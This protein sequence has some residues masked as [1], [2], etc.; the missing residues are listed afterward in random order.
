MKKVSII[1]ITFLFALLGCNKGKQLANELITVDVTNSY[2]QKE[3]I[4]QDF[5]DVEYIPLDDAEEYTTMGWVHSVGKELVIVRNRL[6]KT[7]GK[8]FMFDRNGKGVR[9]INRLGQSGEEYV[10]LLSILLDENKNEIFV[11]DHFTKRILVYDLFGNFK[12]SFN[13]LV[14]DWYD[15]EI[16]NFDNEHL[17]CHTVADQ[18]IVVSKQDGSIADSVEIPAKENISLSVKVGE[19]DEHVRNRRLIPHYDN[20]WILM[21]PSSDTVY[22]FSSDFSMTPIVV[23][24][25][26]ILSMDTKKSLFPVVFTKSYFFMQIVESKWDMETKAFPTTN[27]IYDLNENR[28]FEY[29]VYNAD[30]T[31]TKHPVNMVTDFPYGNNEIAFVQVLHAYELIELLE[32]GH[33]KGRLKEIAA[34]LENE[35]SN[36]VLMVV[37]YKN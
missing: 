32:N 6:Q 27:L 23:R 19:R 20:S 16:Y 2:P 3:L 28:I 24:T 14:K 13:H 33:L 4:L 31:S 9:I 21:Q 8:I 12:R 29:V 17:L 26:S 10:F 25:P 7:D 37:K 35:D 36:P 1:S 22:R 11:N 34:G 18:Y 15:Q 5:M 30:I